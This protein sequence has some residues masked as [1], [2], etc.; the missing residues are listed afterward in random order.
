M[1]TRPSCLKQRPS[2]SSPRLRRGPARPAHG[3]GLLEILIS[4]SITA[5][6]LIACATAFSASASAI[7]NNDAFFRCTQAGRVTLG[8]IL[9]EI[10][11]CDSLDMS[12]AKTIKIIRA[13]PSA[14]NGAVQK[15]SAQPNEVSRAFVYD[16]TNK[17]ITLQ[18]T[19]TATVSPVYELTTNV[20]ACSFGPADMG[21]DYNGLSIP[22]HV[23]I[24]ITISTGG[25]TVALTG[26]A[27]PRRATTY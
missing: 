15:Y 2:Q 1:T 22:I 17:R 24:S 25:N 4:L 13:A 26:S 21:T 3:M 5:L 19:Y 7:N 9:A 16:S 8:Q 11:N 14:Q 18:I 10:R 6:L 23:P 27:V 20:S 12:Q